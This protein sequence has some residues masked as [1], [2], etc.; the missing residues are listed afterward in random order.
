MIPFSKPSITALERRYM[1]EAMEGTAFSGDGP[2]T[3]RATRC[4][5]ETLGIR[6]C[7]LT[8]S[9]T[10]ALE[11][12]A[13]L[14]NLGPGDEVILPSY[15]FSSTA[16]ALML[17]GARPVFCDVREDT[18]NMDEGL[19]E[20]L[21]TG[22]TKAIFTV[23]YAG[24]PCEM[25]V[26]GDIAGRHG[27][28]VV[29]DAAQAV[30]S[31]YRGRPAGTL[32][33]IGCFSFHNTKNYTM[34]EGGAIVLNDAAYTE[35][36]EILREKGT[37]RRK[38]VLGLV[39]KYTWHD[40]GSSFLPSDLLAALLLAQMERFGEIMQRRM[41]LWALYHEGLAGLER[42]GA[43]RRPVVPEGIGHNAHMYYILLPTARERT[44]VLEA[45]AAE[46]ISAY[47]HY[48]PLHSS[49]LGLSLGYTPEQLP[50]T[51][52]CAARL[53]RLPLY[54]D[55]AGEDAQRVLSHLARLCG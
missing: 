50:R 10:T 19:I 15:T 40:V 5:E 42:A 47:F 55:M 7:H 3:A 27:L 43:L 21:I 18:M 32:G 1:A 48:I 16:N 17:R 45:L 49:P 24:V 34:G 39:D 6:R 13:L 11:M 29:E 31:I 2:Y 25:E 44:R 22:R 30:G 23:D 12:A 41:A 4:L 46:G 20:S 36:A 38:A 9:G 26:I 53:L 51:E 28:R 35:R 14:L 8:T 33:E 37:D 52:D 54:T